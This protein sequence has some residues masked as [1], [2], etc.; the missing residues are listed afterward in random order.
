M[1]KYYVHTSKDKDGDHEVH[2]ENCKKLPLPANR[3]YLGVF[4]SCKPAVTEARKYYSPCNGCWHCS[5]ECNT[6]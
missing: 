2:D 6:G 4:S 3:K 1:A 5:R